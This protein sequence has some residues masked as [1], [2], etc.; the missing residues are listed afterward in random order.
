MS[1][2]ASVSYNICS[3]G[4]GLFMYSGSA[5]ISGGKLMYNNASSGN[6]GGVYVVPNYES[7]E[8]SFNGGVIG[9]NTAAN[10]NGIYVQNDT[11][12]MT[13]NMK[14][15]G[16]IASGNTF[17]LGSKQK[18]TVSSA[19]TKPSVGGVIYLARIVPSSYEDGR[20]VLTGPASVV[21]DISDYDWFPLENSHY[22]IDE[23]GIIT[24]N[25]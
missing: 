6:G 10:G 12:V 4:A 15:N 13:I 18:I 23:D 16:Y 11:T 17:Y 19:T 3:V 14:G 1:G 8:F 7:N 21:A 5:T 2:S 20:T 24:E 22:Y 25:L 9:N